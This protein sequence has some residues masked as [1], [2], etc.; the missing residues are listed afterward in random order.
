[1][2]DARGH[3]R[4]IMAPGGWI[5][6][7]NP[8]G[9]DLEMVSMGYRNQY[10]VAF[11]QNG[12]A[13]TYDSD[14]E[15]DMGTPWYRPTRIYHATSGSEFGW[16]SGSGKW[17]DG[18]PD[19]LPQLLDVG[20]GS[21]TGVAFGTGAKFPAKYQRALFAM[22]WSF[23]TLYAVHLQPDGATHKGTKEV[24][25]SRN[26]LPL[27]DLVVH[28]KDGAMYFVTGGRRTASGLYR[29]TY[30]GS[31]STAPVKAEPLT[32]LQQLRRKIESHHREGNPE[33]VNFAWQYLDHPDRFIRFAARIAVELQP[34]EQWQE[35]A[36]AETRPLAL[37]EA[38]IAL[39][40]AGKDK[41]LAPALVDR[42]L[43]QDWAKLD[44]NA[45]MAWLRACSLIFIRQGEPTPEVA[46]KVLARLDS[47]FPT[48]AALVDRELANLLIYLKSPTIVAKA[49][50]QMYTAQD[51][52]EEAFSEEHL[53]RG[54]G[55]GTVVAAMQ[56]EPTHK[57]QIHYAFNLRNATTG[58]TPELRDRYFAWFSQARQWKGGNSFPGFLT[59]SRDE[60]LEPIKDAVEKTRLV[61]L[62]TQSG[63]QVAEL[64]RAKGPGAN[65]TVADFQGLTVEQLQKRDLSH[66]KRMFQAA[67]CAACH[68]FGGEGGVGG[69]DLTG[70]AGRYTVQDLVVAILDPNKEVSD[71]YAFTEFK[72]KNGSSVLGRVAREDKKDYH[73]ITSFLA[74]DAHTALPKGNVKEQ[75]VS[76]ASPMMAGL[77]NSLNREEALDLLGYLLSGTK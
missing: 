22:D 62:A 3:A 75:T 76:K 36:L 72:L 73:L 8:D 64:P 54:G 48:Q 58:W 53:K 33:A 20:P 39:A 67:L 42:L 18:Y 52:K 13:F 37:R 61:T 44:A 68:K 28:P 49:V 69:P 56:K 60:A 59:N 66:G 43:S 15:W 23:G 6:R 45:R 40:R 57:Q 27:A 12:E 55:Y 26:S 9:T 31:E 34:V 74:P 4:G 30:T 24:F 19:S 63:K 17:A 5:A 2:W 41:S 14:M 29:V 32:E 35:K 16:R 65:Y 10:D 11:D 51:A 47:T 1:M 46:Q 71:Q 50:E 21:P 38:V 70:A 25:L 7:I 77:M